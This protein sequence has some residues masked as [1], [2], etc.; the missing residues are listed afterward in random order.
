MRQLVSVVTE[1]TVHYF[2]AEEGS[3][4]VQQVASVL[5]TGLQVPDVIDLGSNL[6]EALHLNGHSKGRKAVAAPAPT[7][8]LPPARPAPVKAAARKPGRPPGPQKRPMRRWGFG[9]DT[10]L[11]DLRAHPGTT[12]RE[13]CLRIAGSEEAGALT[14]YS[15]SLSL[16]ARRLLGSGADIRREPFQAPGPDG[17]LRQYTRLYLVEPAPQEEPQ[18]E[19]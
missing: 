10:V 9:Q 17:G 16:V 7:P 13:A 4:E 5:N 15:A 2:L 6:L 14:A 19:P 12:Y 8:A 18:V 11:A 1:Q 3:D